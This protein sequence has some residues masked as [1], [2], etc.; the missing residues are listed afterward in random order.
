MFD[1]VRRSII[2]RFIKEIDTAG[3]K[4][5]PV[6]WIKFRRVVAGWKLLVGYLVFV[7]PDILLWANSTLPGLLPTLGIED[8]T[9][10]I[11][12]IG[13]VLM[14][15]GAI[16]KFL[17]FLQPVERRKDA[18]RAAVVEE[19]GVAHEVKAEVKKGIKEGTIPPGTVSAVDLHH[20]VQRRIQKKKDGLP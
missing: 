13:T 3:F 9:P 20:E 6:G 16:D 5:W 4:R 10:I 2:M 12:G 11:H 17:K 19:V 8:A 15:V 1:F 14:A 18:R 7:T